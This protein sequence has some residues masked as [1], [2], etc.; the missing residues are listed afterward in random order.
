METIGRV[1]LLSLQ[2]PVVD[3]QA[4][5]AL[6]LTCVMRNERGIHG[7]RMAGNPQVICADGRARVFKLGEV[8]RVMLANCRTRG[9]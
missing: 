6:K 4:I 3:M 9:I 2:S 1:R 7:K 5:N 8:P